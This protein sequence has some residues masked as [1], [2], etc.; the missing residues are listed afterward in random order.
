MQ[1]RKVCNHPYLIPG[2]EEK[3]TDTYIEPEKDEYLV[4]SCSKL[5][6]VDKF[7]K[8]LK[9]QKK[10]VLIFSQMVQSKT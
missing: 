6:F 2:A 3:L 9:E 8:K 1:I 4:K 5:V 10:K 7:L